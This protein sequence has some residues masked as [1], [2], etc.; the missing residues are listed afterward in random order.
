[1]N[2]LNNIPVSRKI[3]FLAF[4]LIAL[5]LITAATAI[6]SMAK[7][8]NELESIAHKDMPL[9]EKITK[10]TEH[11]LEQAIHFERALHFGTVGI[12]KEKDGKSDN[13]HYKKIFTTEREKF[14]SLGDKV[15]RELKESQ[16]QIKNILDTQTQARIGFNLFPV[17]ADEITEFQLMAEE[18]N[19]IDKEHKELE[20]NGIASLTAIENR[21]LDRAEKLALQLEKEED[22]LTTHLENLLTTI[23]EFTLEGSE[24]ALQHEKSAVN[25]IVTVLVLA[26]A[27]GIGISMII[28]RNITSRLNGAV[29]SMNSVAEGDLT[30]EVV[31]SGKDEISRMLIALEGTRENLRSII[32]N[33]SETASQLSVT[34]E[35]VSTA[36]SES[37]GH[38]QG[39][40]SQTETL[41]T[42]MQQMN[43]TTAEISHN[44]HQMN[45]S[46]GHAEQ[47]LQV[48]NQ[49]LMD[50]VEQTAQLST[51]IEASAQTIQALDNSALNISSVLRVITDIAEQTNLLALNAA[52][53][54]ARAGEQGRGFAVVADEV[55]QLASR[56]QSST[57]EISNIITELQAGSSRVVTTMKDIQ[58]KATSLAEGAN[59]SQQALSSVASQME[60]I[61]NMT[62]QIAA[63]SEEQSLVTEDSSRNVTYINDIGHQNSSSIEETSQASLN[64]ANMAEQLK[65][66]V[67]VFR[68]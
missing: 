26:I 8:G 64:L 52:I 48:S 7:I 63:A 28:T 56:T 10:I 51:Q 11:Q 6:V 53:E 33:I 59:H 3:G 12:L 47:E 42:S 38:V 40:Q 19:T 60:T 49:I 18:L 50:T 34:S 54:A 4:A 57:A 17:Y 15:S 66:S 13:S 2:T 27:V 1:M 39:Q 32:G 31:V 65:N 25:I 20:L 29:E 24:T 37:S 68:V 62:N 61:N 36:M 22:H 9:I 58:V 44:I 67:T 43:A 46:V 14:L 30:K 16:A 41:A 5:L 45:D 21:K 35:Q 23:E 55:R